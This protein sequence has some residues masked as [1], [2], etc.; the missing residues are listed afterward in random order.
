MPE[1]SLVELPPLEFVAEELRPLHFT[2]SSVDDAPLR[3]FR[4]QRI[5]RALGCLPQSVSLPPSL[6]SSPA[7]S[8][9][10]SQVAGQYREDFPRRRGTRRACFAGAL[11]IDICS[12]Q[13]R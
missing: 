11:P 12:Q 4:S 2:P 13:I 1:R 5:Q 3:L 9:G 8:A 6:S 7:R 10:Q